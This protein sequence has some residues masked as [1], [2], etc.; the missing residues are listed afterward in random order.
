LHL[1]DPAYEAGLGTVPS[2]HYPQTRLPQDA[3]DLL[4]VKMPVAAVLRASKG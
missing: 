2:R 1:R 3:H 4:H